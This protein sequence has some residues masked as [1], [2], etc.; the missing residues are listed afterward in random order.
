MFIS[1]ST[2]NCFISSFLC[3]Y[4]LSFAQGGADKGGFA[5]IGLSCFHFPQVFRFGFCYLQVENILVIGHSRCGGIRALMSMD[6][7]TNSR[8]G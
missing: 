8:F 5:V 6:D 4:L 2:S 7:E 1:F 3:I